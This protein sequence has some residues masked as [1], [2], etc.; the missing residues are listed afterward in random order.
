MFLLSSLLTHL[1]RVGS[2]TLTDANGRRYVF[3]GAPGP[4]LAIRLKD[5]ALSRRLFLNPSLALG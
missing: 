3:A 4:S 2:L 5:P 1:I